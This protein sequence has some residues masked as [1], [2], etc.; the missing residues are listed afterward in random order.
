VRSYLA[1]TVLRE[2]FLVFV[3]GT[4]VVS[5]VTAA[6]H[7]GTG[8]GRLAVLPALA[9]LGV[10]EGVLG[11]DALTFVTDF[12]WLGEAPASVVAVTVCLAWAAAW[13]VTWVVVM[14]IAV[15]SRP[16]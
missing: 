3:V 4:T 7:R 13:V 16:T 5:A 14:D 12:L 6:F 15:Q 9:V 11:S 10:T 8:W 1:E 2:F